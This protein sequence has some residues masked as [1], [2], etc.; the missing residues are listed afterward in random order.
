MNLATKRLTLEEYLTYDD[1]TDKQYELVAGEL[2]EMPAESPLNVQIALF[3]LSHLLQFVP[4][5]CL[6]NKAEI[7]VSGVRA[8]TRIPDLTV[9]SVE[10][11]AILRET[12]RSTILLDMPPPLL[13]VEVVSPGKANEDRD[14]RYKR[15]EYAARGIAEYWI[16][17]PLRAQVTVLTLVD[18]FYEEQVWRGEEAIASTLFPTLN[19]TVAAVLQAGT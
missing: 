9:F 18:G 8:T 10:L 7:V 1:G 13:V 6:S 17:D 12:K 5:N 4:L 19:L 11:A 16:V 2:V 3:L 15:S 14:Y